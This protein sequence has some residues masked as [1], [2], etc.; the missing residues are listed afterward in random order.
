MVLKSLNVAVNNYCNS[1]C[2][3]CFMWKNKHNDILFSTEYKLLFDR[4][5]FKEVE[6]LSLTG[7]EPFLRV[8]LTEITRTIISELPKLRALFVNTNGTY[9]NLVREFVHIFAHQVPELFIFVSIEG[10]KETHKKVRG[11]DSFDLAIATIKAVQSERFRNVHTIISTTLTKYNCDIENLEFI[12]QLSRQLS[13]SFTFRLADN[14]SLYYQNNSNSAFKVNHTCYD[15]IIEFIK[16]YKNEDPFM[17]IFCNFLATGKVNFMG[18]KK[19]KIKC[20]AGDIFAFIHSD[21]SIYPCIYSTRKIGDL[22]KGITY[23]PIDDLG[24]YEPCP[25]CTECNIYPMLKFY[26]YITTRKEN[27]KN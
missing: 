6:D 14:S 10:D 11:I 13:S 23:S 8:D 16:K 18:D 20:G 12:N 21:G 17:K 25:C 27:D 5:E 9:P 7:G 26:N 24:K 3:M 22:Y 19:N 1:K 4:P 15:S 2:K